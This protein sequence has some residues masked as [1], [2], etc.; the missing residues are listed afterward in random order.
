VRRKRAP[1]DD[2]KK[3]KEVEKRQRWNAEIIT[4]MAEEE[5]GA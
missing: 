2:I 4:V 1:L 3:K 5:E